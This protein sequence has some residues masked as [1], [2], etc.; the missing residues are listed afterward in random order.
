MMRQAHRL[1]LPSL[2]VVALGSAPL[3]LAAQRTSIGWDRLAVGALALGLTTT[4]DATV[5]R[6]LAGSHSGVERFTGQFTRFGEV[7]VIVPVIGGLT[8]VGL[9]AGRPELTR[10]AGQSTA[11]IAA[12][13]ISVTA[14]KHLV[15]RTRPYD[16]LRL[17][18]S[19]W[20]P[21]SGETAW[22]SG[23]TAAAFAVA[24]TLADAID[25]KLPRIGLYG[26]A[27]ATGFSRMTA[28]KHWFSD[29]VAGAAIGVTAGKLANGRWS[30]LGLRA[31][32]LLVGPGTAGVG[33]TF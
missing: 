4:F 6:V 30:L 33:W 25:R 1:L 26:L 16:D 21:F 9:L 31:P 2:L 12:V 29:V 27:L 15:G 11:A 3:P 14:L 10:L 22:P 23:H 28:S 32:R 5:A 13:A 19:A 18:G 24:T 7:G 20:S 8:L 17:S